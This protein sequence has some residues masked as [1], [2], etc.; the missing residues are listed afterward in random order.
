MR[1]SG[2]SLRCHHGHEFYRVE[3]CLL[4]AQHKTR[5]G[6]KTNEITL[7]ISISNQF[8]LFVFGNKYIV[9][10]MVIGNENGVDGRS[11]RI[12]DERKRVKG[13]LVRGAFFFIVYIFS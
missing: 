11:E 9:I 6:R 12:D 10:R 8:R 1:T 13:A 3:G 5:K 4:L 7:R 2:C